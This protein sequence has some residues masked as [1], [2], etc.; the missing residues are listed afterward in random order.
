MLSRGSGGRCR[1]GATD[2]ASRFYPEGCGFESHL[3][4]VL[5]L[6]GATAA[7]THT[8]FHQLACMLSP[9]L[10]PSTYDTSYVSLSPT[11]APIQSIRFD[12]ISFGTALTASSLPPSWPQHSSLFTCHPLPSHL[13][14]APCLSS[15]LIN[16]ALFSMDQHTSTFASAICFGTLQ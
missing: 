3:R 14:L 11:L 5:V 4:Y 7:S 13:H 1:S 12:Y 8:H 16:G 15:T 6:G 9:S 10:A 2:S